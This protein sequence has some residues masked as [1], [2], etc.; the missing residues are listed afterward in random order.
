MLY[1]SS[2]L[3]CDAPRRSIISGNDA[4]EPATSTPLTCFVLIVGLVQRERLR[5]TMAIE[6]QTETDTLEV[7]GRIMDAIVTQRLAPGQKVSEN[8]LT[9]MFDISRT[10][11]RNAMEQMTAQQFMI[12]PSP[13]ITR[14]SSLTLKDV[15]ENFMIRK[16]VE[17]SVLSM[18]S[19]Q[20]EEVEFR[21][22]ND[23]LLHK[24]PID[25]DDDALRLLKANR[26]FN[27]YIAQ[28]TQFPLLI[29]WIRQLEETTMRIYW[30]YIKLTKALP[31]GWEQHRGLLDLV[32]DNQTDEIRKY[33]IMMISSCE[34]R[35]LNAI[36]THGKLNEHSLNF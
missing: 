17:P 26:D 27:I 1:A 31:Y 34:D 3:D 5:M 11:A 35:V 21:R 14:I 29:S 13:R 36:F 30:I 6:V 19:P 8:I 2:G 12:S 22:R 33:T 16:M 15:K 10:A 23:A 18:I 32:K 9:R 25:N 24:G 7:Y 28:Q 20:I 4:P